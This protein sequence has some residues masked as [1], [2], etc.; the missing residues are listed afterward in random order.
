MTILDGATTGAARATSP[1]ATSNAAAAPA[2]EAGRT[3]RC[4]FC[5]AD[6][7]EDRGQPA[8][9]ACPLSRGCH[10]VRC[11]TCGYENPVTPGWIRRLET[12]WRKV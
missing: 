5:G 8:C 3:V 12:W 2:P 4:A 9:A 6:F 1:T 7:A 10:N 11:P